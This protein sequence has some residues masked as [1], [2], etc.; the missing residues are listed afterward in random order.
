MQSPLVSVIIPVYNGQQ[1][2]AAAL[3]SVVKQD[4]SPLEIIVVDDGSTDESARVAQAY[5]EVRYLYQPN[6][7]A[8]AARNAGIAAA[9]GALIAFLDHDDLWM[10]NKLRLHANYL[11]DNPQ[12]RFT[13]STQLIYLEEGVER[14]DWL[15]VE[16]IEYPQPLLSALV[17]RKETFFEIGVFDTSFK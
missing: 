7:G 13:I 9:E 11:L 10:P 5:P 6:Q 15:R 16:D 4:Y 1:Y 2:L 3:D 12:V 14:P 8:A 17:V